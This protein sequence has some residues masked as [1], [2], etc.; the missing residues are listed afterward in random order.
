MKK[1]LIL[2]LIGIL[3]VGCETST[4][5]DEETLIGTCPPDYNTG[6]QA[7]D[8]SITYPG[9]DSNV[10]S[11][12]PFIP[13][14]NIYDVGEI[15]SDGI[16]LLSGLDEEVFSGL[17]GCHSLDF[18]ITQED[19]HSDYFKETKVEFPQSSV[20]AEENYEETLTV[21]TRYDYSNYGIF[22]LCLTDDPAAETECN[23]DS[24]KNKLS[25]SSA[26]PL[27]VNSIT[28]EIIPVG[29]DTISVVLNIKADVSLS[30]NQQLMPIEDLTSTDCLYINEDLTIKIDADVILFGERYY[31][32]YLEFEYGEND[33]ELQCSI[34]NID[35]RSLVGGHKEQS[36]WVEIKYGIEEKQ[37]VKFNVNA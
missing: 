18:Y 16:V 27:Q 1:I 29:G 17:G 23:A 19:S 21:T 28:Q 13:Q 31:C 33:A 14:I 30:N 2:M 15:G 25:K 22:E 36:G 26:G 37:S 4:T 7:L 35:L 12:Y 34:E 10:Y 6:S 8:I 5:V 32:D 9:E 24:K 3:L 20:N 11:R